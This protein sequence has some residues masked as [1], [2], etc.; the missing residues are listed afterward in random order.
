MSS[1][2]IDLSHPIGPA[3]PVYPRYPRVTVTVLDSTSKSTPAK[4]HLN[5]SHVGLGVHTGT[6]LDAPLHFYGDKRSID[7]TPLQAGIGRC[8]LIR[9]GSIK[10]RGRIDITDL[11]PHR[12]RLR[13]TPRVLLDTGWASQW[14]ARHYFSRH[15]VLTGEAAEF[16]V[17]CGIALVGVD[18]PSVDRP[19]FA[20]HLEL[21]GNDVLIL[22]NLTNLASIN[23]SEFQLIAVPLKLEER[24]ASPVRVLAILD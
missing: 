22:E 4:R 13:K 3:T 14:G 7:R 17:E 15:P 6:H 21:L 10:P 2:I 11:A 8:L 9:L 16:L 18:M 12:D 23:G 5:S 24:E 1:R 19:P 20:A